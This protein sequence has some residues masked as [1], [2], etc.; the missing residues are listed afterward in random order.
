MP[1]VTRFNV[2]KVSSGKALY[3]SHNFDLG[4]MVWS[5]DPEAAF[6]YDDRDEA[7]ADALA[8]GGDVFPFERQ[9]RHSDFILF[10][11]VHG[12]QIAAE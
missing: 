8:W 2:E 3:L 11:I 7:D 1:T 12:A 9:A 10:P 6:E 5:A 4:K